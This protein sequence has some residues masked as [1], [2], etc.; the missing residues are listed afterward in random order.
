MSP[1]RPSDPLRTCRKPQYATLLSDLSSG[2]SENIA[3]RQEMGRL[4]AEFVSG[5]SIGS[6]LLSCGWVGQTQ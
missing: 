2:W 4:M 6:L 5:E 1:T 3:L